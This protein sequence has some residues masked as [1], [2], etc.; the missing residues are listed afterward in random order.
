[1]GDLPNVTV[2]EG[3]TLNQVLTVPGVTLTQLKD[4]DGTAL[5]IHAKADDNKTDPSGNSGA[6][7]AC[8]VFVRQ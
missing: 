7:L 4:A 2:A 1:M 3:G 8:G 5:V 6:R